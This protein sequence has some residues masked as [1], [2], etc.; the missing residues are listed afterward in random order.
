M[1]K[2]VYL[3]ARKRVERIRRDIKAWEQSVQYK[4]I[5]KKLLKTLQ[6]GSRG[7]LLRL[8][9]Q[10]RLHKAH[11]EYKAVAKHANHLRACLSQA[12]VLFMQNLYQT[13]EIAKQIFSK[14]PD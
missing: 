14:A 13:E 11:P 10:K 7:R 6:T 1:G 4:I 5:N 9:L 8:H 2:L 3:E 12:M